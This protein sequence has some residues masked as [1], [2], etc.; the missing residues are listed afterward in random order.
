MRTYDDEDEEDLF[1]EE[2]SV[3]RPYSR[4]TYLPPAFC[5][6]SLPVRELTHLFRT[7]DSTSERVR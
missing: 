7:M 1:D 3:G 2:V 6:L 5:D 4:T